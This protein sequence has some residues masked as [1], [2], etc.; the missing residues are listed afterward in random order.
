[1][2]EYLKAFLSGLTDEQADELWLYFDGC[3]VGDVIELI[4]DSHPSVKAKNQADVDK[5]WGH[6][7]ELAPGPML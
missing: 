1:M 7:Y 4:A 2:P 3:D 6:E 5:E